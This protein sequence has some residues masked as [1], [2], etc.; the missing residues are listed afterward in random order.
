MK[1][2]W[3][4]LTLE[5]IEFP[6][7]GGNGSTLTSCSTSSM[8]SSDSQSVSLDSSSWGSDGAIWEVLGSGIAPKAIREDQL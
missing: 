5:E 6:R 8:I 7:D 3:I 2:F 1:V 4:S